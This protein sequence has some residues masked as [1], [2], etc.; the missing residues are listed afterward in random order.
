MKGVTAYY[1]PKTALGKW[2]IGLIVGSLFFVLLAGLIDEVFGVIGAVP[3]NL[4]LVAGISGIFAFFTGIIGIIKSR[5]HSVI[6][7][8]ATIIG[9]L[10]FLVSV[11]F[12]EY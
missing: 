5:D 9:F 6:V 2:S 11:I 12:G 4:M 3:N 1:K 10:I 7:Y 8:I